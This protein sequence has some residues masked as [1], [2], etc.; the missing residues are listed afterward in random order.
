MDNLIVEKSDYAH[1][2]K[3]SD[4]VTRTNLGKY[5]KI[6]YIANQSKSISFYFISLSNAIFGVATIDFKAFLVY[7]T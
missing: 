4:T 2:I 1:K 7:T 6:T 3:A 5:S